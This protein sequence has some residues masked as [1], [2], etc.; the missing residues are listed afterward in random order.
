M[1]A[2]S[3]DDTSKPTT[4]DLETSAHILGFFKSNVTRPFLSMTM[5]VMRYRMQESGSQ[6]AYVMG[7]PCVEGHPTS[8]ADTCS[9]VVRRGTRGGFDGRSLTP[10]FAKKGAVFTYEDRSSIAAKMKGCLHVLRSLGQLRTGWALF[11][12]EQELLRAEDCDLELVRPAAHGRIRTVRAILD[13][14]GRS[15]NPRARRRRRRR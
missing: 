9:S 15:A 11:D 8:F 1:R 4:P 6:S 13:A 14:L 2:A 12:I 7:V 5:A 10:W 3:N